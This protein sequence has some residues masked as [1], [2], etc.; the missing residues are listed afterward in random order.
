MLIS[1]ETTVAQIVLHK[2][3]LKQQIEVPLILWTTKT[4]LG[5]FTGLGY[6]VKTLCHVVA[7]FTFL[8]KEA[9]F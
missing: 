2:L 3:Y 1:N 8:T 4:N 6:T 9:N 5:K 7:F